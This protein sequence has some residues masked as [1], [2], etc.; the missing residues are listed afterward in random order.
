MGV[1]GFVPFVLMGVLEVKCC[2][3]G[4]GDCVKRETVEEGTVLS[5]GEFNLPGLEQ[6]AILL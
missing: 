4:K 1:C 5:V 2:L 3:P 6:I